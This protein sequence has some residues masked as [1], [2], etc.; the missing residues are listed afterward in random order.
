MLNLSK[1]SR[2]I[3]LHNHYKI[4]ILEPIKDKFNYTK[5][6]IHKGVSKEDLMH[7]GS[8]NTQATSYTIKVKCLFYQNIKVHYAIFCAA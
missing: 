4:L 5:R 3:E 8:L 1:S 2:F 6:R 7:F